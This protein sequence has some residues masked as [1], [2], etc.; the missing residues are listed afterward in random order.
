MYYIN[1]GVYGSF[2]NIMFDHAKAEPLVLT[3]NSQMVSKE[4][5]RCPYYWYG[6]HNKP[7]ITAPTPYHDI[8]VLTPRIRHKQTIIGPVYESSLWGPTCD[9]LDCISKNACLPELAIGDWLYFEEMGAY[10][11][12]AASRFNGFNLSRI[13]YVQTEAI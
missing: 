6:C 13:F 7:T 3:Q 10:T 1:D 8:C 9:S 4:V 5:R 11:V 12:A 2:N